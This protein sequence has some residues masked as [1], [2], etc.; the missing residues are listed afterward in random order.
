MAGKVKLPA[1]VLER[2]KEAASA[3]KPPAPPPA[4]K[5]ASKGAL[6]RAKVVA[7]LKKLHPMD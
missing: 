7:A 4:P 5:V 2:A 6:T 3:R 1:H